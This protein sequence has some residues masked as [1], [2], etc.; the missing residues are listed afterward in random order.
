MVWMGPCL[1]HDVSLSASSTSIQAL[2]YLLG[3]NGSNHSQKMGARILQRFSEIRALVLC[4]T[5]S[6]HNEDTPHGKN[7]K[8]PA[9][10]DVGKG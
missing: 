3:L 8:L 4:G 10:P 6:A 5:R 2:W 1:G 7:N 9:K